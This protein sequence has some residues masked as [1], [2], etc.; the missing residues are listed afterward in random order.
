M[1]HLAFLGL[2]DTDIEEPGMRALRE[3]ASLRGCR[4]EGLD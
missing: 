2:A 3:S 1:A 4:I